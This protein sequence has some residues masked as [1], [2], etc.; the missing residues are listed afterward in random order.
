MGPDRAGWILL[1]ESSTTAVPIL[2]TVDF[3][4]DNWRSAEVGYSDLDIQVKPAL[5]SGGERTVRGCSRVAQATRLVPRTVR[6]PPDGGTVVPPRGPP[7]LCYP[8]S[9]AMRSGLLWGASSR[10]II[11]SG[12]IGV[13]LRL[14]FLTRV[15][16]WEFSFPSHSLSSPAA[17]PT[18]F[19]SQLLISRALTTFIS[20]R[21]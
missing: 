15:A 1:G 5:A 2:E 17:G 12:G 6:S 14:T 4:V 21:C 7:R 20:D 16:T 3:C 18:L 19:W 8:V 13:R 9:P 11:A 10:E